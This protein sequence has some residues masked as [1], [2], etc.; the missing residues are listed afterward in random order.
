M[1][2]DVNFSLTQRVISRGRLQRR[3]ESLGRLQR[4]PAHRSSAKV[5]EARMLRKV[6]LA[7]LVAA[8]V[9]VTLFLPSSNTPT[10]LALSPQVISAGWTHTCSVASSALYCW[11]DDSYGELGDG[12][13]S[14]V[15]VVPERIYPLVSPRSA[16]EMDSPART[17][18]AVPNVPATTPM[19]NWATTRPV[20]PSTL[21]RFSA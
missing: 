20:A 16:L 11:G 13:P 8:L 17:L 3:T 5:A 1:S 2:I 12:Q 6:W 14:S 10:A 21:Y 15:Q 18:A 19:V 9:L 4:R 7:A